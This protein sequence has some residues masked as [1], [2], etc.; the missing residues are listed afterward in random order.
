MSTPARVLVAA[1]APMVVGI[2]GHKLR[3]EGHEVTEARGS[4]QTAHALRSHPFDAAVCEPSLV[5]DVTAMPPWLAI[6]DGRDDRAGLDAMHL[7]AAGLVRTPFK[8]TDV[9]AQVATLLSIA[10]VSA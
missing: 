4:A 3:R 10:A 8:P 9:A 6:V 1:D 5:N 7:G 2:L